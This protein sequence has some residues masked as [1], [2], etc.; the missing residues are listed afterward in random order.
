MG[1]KNWDALP[2]IISKFLFSLSLYL[3]CW[4]SALKNW[5][6]KCYLDKNGLTY[7]Q[8]VWRH[9]TLDFNTGL[10]VTSFM[11]APYDERCQ[12]QNNDDWFKLV[13]RDIKKSIT[14]R[15]RG[16]LDLKLVWI[17]FSRHTKICLIFKLV[18]TPSEFLKKS[19]FFKLV[20]KIF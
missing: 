1:P 18:K 17:Y 3:N 20:C 4:S 10:C 2:L 9:L 19:Q 12:K 5:T 13:Q 6:V 16:C 11:N 7:F 15:P 14:L 8:T